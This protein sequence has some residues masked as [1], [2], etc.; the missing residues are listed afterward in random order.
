M[1]YG[2]YEEASR[3]MVVHISGSIMYS[4]DQLVAIV[5]DRAAVI[6]MQ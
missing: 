2:L 1:E 4:T 6:T 3:N 5:S